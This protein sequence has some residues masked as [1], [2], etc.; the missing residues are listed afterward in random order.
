MVKKPSKP[1]PE[2]PPP[3]RQSLDGIVLH[4]TKLFGTIFLGAS[5]ID[6]LFKGIYVPFFDPPLWFTWSVESI[7][8]GVILFFLIVTVLDAVFSV[9]FHFRYRIRRKR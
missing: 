5:T 8:Y 7:L 4:D 3:E 6:F 1:R 2:A 9:Y